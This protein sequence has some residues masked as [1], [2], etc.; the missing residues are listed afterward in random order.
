MVVKP[1][2]QL[3]AAQIVELNGI[4]DELETIS[5]SATKLAMIVAGLIPD[6]TPMQ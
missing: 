6:D 2:E 3:T 1:L 4:K 5:N